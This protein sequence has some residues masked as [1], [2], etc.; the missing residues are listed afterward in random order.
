MLLYEDSYVNETYLEGHFRPRSGLNVVQKLRLRL[1]WQQEGLLPSSIFQRARR[2]DQWNV[3]SR[4]DYTRYW[5]AL[6]LQPQF[7]FM[8]LR[9]RD[10]GAERSLRSEVSLIPILRAEYPLMSR[11]TLQVGIQG[12]GGFPYRFEDRVAQRH[13]FE[14]RTKFVNLT[15]ESSYFGY[16]LFTIIGNH[17]RQTG[18]RRRPAEVRRVRHLVVLHS[19][20]RR[21]HP[22][23]PADLRLPRLH[24][25]CAIVHSFA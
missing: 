1:N 12:I 24:D 14:R 2:L 3:V 20:P 19:H 6:K 22:V 8:F 25:N 10:Q 18:L 16:E 5:G 15:N 21:L 9:L 13:S 11:S 17:Q 4:A 23:R 7:K